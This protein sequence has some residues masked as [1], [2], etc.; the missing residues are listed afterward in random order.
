MGKLLYQDDEGTTR[1]VPRLVWEQMIADVRNEVA[2]ELADP[3]PGPNTAL[4]RIQERLIVIDQL[5]EAYKEK[6][7]DPY[8][9]K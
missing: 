2:K 5:M 9:E 3:T 6:F 4:E 8:P 7:G 1:E